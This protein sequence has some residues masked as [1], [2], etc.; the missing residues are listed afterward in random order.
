MCCHVQ[1]AAQGLA[2]LG[3]PVSP[4]HAWQPAP[5][6]ELKAVERSDCTHRR[7]PKKRRASVWT[8]AEEEATLHT[9]RLREMP[10]NRFGQCAGGRLA[11]GVLSGAPGDAPGQCRGSIMNFMAS[12]RPAW[13]TGSAVYEEQIGADRDMAVDTIEV[14]IEDG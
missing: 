4:R 5:C 2:E 12:G 1:Q 11:A 6:S 13:H 10:P 9:F 3:Q 14:I 7:R 8:R